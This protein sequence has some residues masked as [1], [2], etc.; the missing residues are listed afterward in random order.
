MNKEQNK[1]FITNTQN[2][3]TGLRGLKKEYLPEGMAILSKI[4]KPLYGIA[5]NHDEWALLRKDDVAD[6][7]ASTGGLWLEDGDSVVYDNRVLLVTKYQPEGY[8]DTMNDA[9]AMKR[10]MLN[11]YPCIV[12]SLPKN[13][14][15]LILAGHTHGGQVRVPFI[16][17]PI[18]EERDKVYSKGLFLTEAGPMY[19]STGIGTFFWSV[20]FMCRLE[21][22]IIEL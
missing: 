19:V 2:P 7:F 6:D 5:G 8:G 16:E 21:I 20:R 1:D 9:G 11:H 18:L 14:F 4:N 22:T 10:I 13:S 3:T 12:D 15:D 17:N